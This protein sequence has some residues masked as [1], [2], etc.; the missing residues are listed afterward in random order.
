M[1]EG[2]TSGGV[3]SVKYLEELYKQRLVDQ[4]QM[5][6]SSVEDERVFLMKNHP[7]LATKFSGNLQE[8]GLQLLRAEAERKAAADVAKVSSPSSLGSSG[9]GGGG[10]G[11][12]AGSSSRSRKSAPKKLRQ[13]EMSSPSHR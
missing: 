6:T 11:G 3:P 9:G 4:F 5:K 8:F 2:S 10:G 7:D 13:S 1:T 12:G